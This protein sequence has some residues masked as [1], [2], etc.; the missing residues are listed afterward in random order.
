ML[1]FDE[2]GR[3]TALSAVTLWSAV[4]RRVFAPK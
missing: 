3:S 1:V 4:S 2:M